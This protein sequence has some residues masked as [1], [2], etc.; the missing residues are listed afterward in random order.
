[1]LLKAFTATIAA[2]LISF[3]SG[4][5]FTPTYAQSPATED[6]GTQVYPGSYFEQYNPQTAWDMVDHLPGFT[7]DTGE[8]LRGFGGGAGNV[9]INGARASSK[10]GGVEDALERISA[11]SVDRIEVIRGTAG[12]SEAAGQAVVANVITKKIPQ[13]ARWETQLE[14]AAHGKTN[15]AAELAFSKTIGDWETSTKFNT[16][17]E[18]RPLDGTR[19]SR[20]AGGVVTFSELESRP[21]EVHHGAVST[22]VKR[23]TGGG[24]LTFTGRLSHTPGSSDTERQGFEGESLEGTADERRTI[25]FERVATEAEIGLDWTRDFSKDW[26]LKILALSS[27]TDINAQTLVFLERPVGSEIS[28]SLFDS[29]QES[30]E[31]VLRTTVSRGGERRLRPEFGAEITYN[32]LDSILSLHVENSAG[33]TEIA[34]PAANILVEEMRGEAFANLL[35]KVSKKFTIET[36]LGAELSEISVSGDAD[37]T[38]SFFFEKPFATLIYD[39]RPGVQFRIGARRIVGQLDFSDFAAS[40]SAADDRFLGGNPAL[41]PDQ[42]TRLSTSVDLRSE[43]RGALN[44]ELF[45]EWRDDIQE[46]VILPS[47]AQGLGNAGSARVWGLK[48]NASLPLSAVLPGGLL[49]VEAEFLDS[50]FDDPITSEQR[51]VSNI[52]SPNIFAEFRQDLTERRIAWGFSYR[53]ET[54]GLFFFADEESFNRD[55]RHWSAFIETTRVLGIKTS[56]EF[57]GIGKQNFFRERRFFNPDRDGAFDGS[58]TVSRDRGMFITLTMSGQF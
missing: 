26:A 49:E 19:I 37:N 36:G 34:L 47:G 25:E 29:R 55:G 48:T 21:S 5:L 12:S 24:L 53:A 22:E 57:S 28:N 17:L 7:V 30:I 58:Q 4:A 43:T 54:D 35:W 1:M 33:I 44:V 9:L 31:T 56:L 11:D 2:I 18:R 38:K 10:T 41:G 52:D 45:H 13:S 40:A 32:R 51:V 50:T 42:T 39:A 46:Q 6:V 16:Y 15:A 8:D 27:L 14:H 20:N 3:L 23:G